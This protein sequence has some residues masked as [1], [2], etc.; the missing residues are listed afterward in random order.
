M[1]GYTGDGTTLSMDDLVP[2]PE[3]KA[4]AETDT[5]TD[6]DTDTEELQKNDLN[7]D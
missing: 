7:N 5:D 1:T 3:K 2:V 6:T 4:E